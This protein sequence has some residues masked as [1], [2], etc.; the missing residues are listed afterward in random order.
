MKRADESAIHVSPVHALATEKNTS[1]TGQQSLELEIPQTLRTEFN[2]LK[3]PFFDLAGDSKRAKIEINES[4][5][6]DE[7]TF[8][9]LWR[10]TRN[11]ES[12]FPGD[13]E[14]RVHRAIEQIIN[15]APKPI[16]N[17]LPIGSVH[18]L[19]R[20][21]GIVADS[22][23]NYQDIQRA[24][25]NIVKTSV[26]AEGTFQLKESKTRK[27]INDT[28]HLYDRV[29]FKGEMLPSG[30]VAD[31]I[32]LMLGSWYLQN[33]NNNYVVPLDW[34]F[35]NQ[36][37]GS[38]T[39]R[40]YEFLSIHFFVALE[41]R[42]EYH[43]VRY[44][45]ICEYFPL[46]MQ[47]PGWK[48]RKQLKQAHELLTREGYFAKIEWLEVNEPDDWLIR[49]WIGNRARD[50]YLRNKT[51]VRHIGES[52]R[53]VPLPERRRRQLLAEN[54]ANKPQEAQ[55]SRLE[56]DLV[57][58]W[59]MTPST[60]KSLQK[61]HPEARIREVMDWA[62]WVKATKPA[63]I[64]KNPAGWIRKCLME[65]WSAP[66]G[67][68]SPDEVLRQKQE[69]E[70]RETTQRAQLEA[71]Q[72]EDDWKLWYTST[73]QQRVKGELWL[74]AAK[75]KRE[76]DGKEPSQ[77]EHGQKEAELMA[78]LPSNIEKQQQLFGFVKYPDQI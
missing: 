43:D 77:D 25:K 9:I 39:T 58:L 15:N 54:G 72:R 61:G 71:E 48:A 14:K 4:V 57:E 70:A 44:K 64:Q 38:I 7:G 18:Y 16:Q 59:G 41:K 22:G 1:D 62:A 26:E 47:R 11:I 28:F 73:P 55:N 65:N 8:R 45:E 19:A 23:K 51:E 37:Q 49:Y 78:A 3:Y 24:L 46:V 66:A 56:R 21:M 12:K 30:E 76:H 27:F 36:L 74:W 17:P 69:Q 32:Y 63:L 40:M 29:I 68:V 42:R 10:V 5:V 34:R 75:Y 50:E 53:P 31:S 35:Y 20:L 67:Y 52:A 13:F 33:I 60:A 2:F 6:T